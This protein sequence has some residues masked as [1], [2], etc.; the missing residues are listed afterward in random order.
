MIRIMIVVSALISGVTPDLFIDRIRT[1]RVEFLAPESI[2]LI[3][4][5]SIY[6]VKDKNAALITPGKIE[7]RVTLINV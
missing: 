4:T 6:N 5:S 1:G 3:T 7:G 2:L